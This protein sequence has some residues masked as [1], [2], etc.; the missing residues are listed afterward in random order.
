VRFGFGFDSG[1][2]SYSLEG[3][4]S[5]HPH[6]TSPFR[7]IVETSCSG[8]TD[9]RPSL[10]AGGIPSVEALGVAFEAVV[11]FAVWAKMWKTVDDQSVVGPDQMGWTAAFGMQYVDGEGIL[12]AGGK[13]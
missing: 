12:S 1:N 6:Q 8:G 11:G 3:R 13:P 10:A 2:H 5:H 7:S 4:P 9:L